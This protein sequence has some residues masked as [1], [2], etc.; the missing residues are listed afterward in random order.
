MWKRTMQNLHCRQS[1]RIMANG[2]VRRESSLLIQFDGPTNWQLIFSASDRARSEAQIRS[3]FNAK[4]TSTVIHRIQTIPF[5]LSE[6][7]NHRGG[8]PFELIINGHAD[9]STLIATIPERATI[10]EVFT[11][12]L[13]YFDKKIQ[14]K[15]Q[16][17][18]LKREQAREWSRKREREREM[19]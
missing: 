9:G 11:Y 17:S 19:L 16:K 12:V 5:A 2:W 6:T 10:E 1:K 4:Q 18:K 8:L 14:N 13:Q 3:S 7:L 15:T